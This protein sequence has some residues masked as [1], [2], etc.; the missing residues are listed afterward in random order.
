MA[1]TKDFVQLDES[2]QKLSYLLKAKTPG[3][4]VYFWSQDGLDVLYGRANVKY[5]LQC[6][7]HID[8]KV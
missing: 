5:S 2:H 3:P 8:V 7:R 1:D 6:I 4:S